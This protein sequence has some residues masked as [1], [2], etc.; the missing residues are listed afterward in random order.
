MNNVE[1]DFYRRH[2][3]ISFIVT[4]LSKLGRPITKF[5]FDIFQMIPIVFLLLAC[6]CNLNKG[7]E[8]PKKILISE[9]LTKDRS[10]VRESMFLELER[11]TSYIDIDLDG[12]SVVV[13]QTSISTNRASKKSLEVLLAIDLS[14]NRLLEGQKYMVIG[15]NPQEARNYDIVP[16]KP[17]SKFK[18]VNSQ[19]NSYNWLNVEDKRH[20]VIF[21]VYSSNKKIFED[22]S[23][24]PYS[25][26]P[27]NQKKMV[28]DLEHY[29]LSNLIDVVII[30]GIHA[31]DTCNA[32][33]TLLV[34]EHVDEIDSFFN[35]I[36]ASNTLS[37]SRCG[38]VFKKFAFAD[39]KASKPTPGKLNTS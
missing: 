30:N 26:G 5:N 9:I 31:A 19:L 4:F 23:V 8:N 37:I 10:S 13:A 11:Y 33:H 6:G 22:P 1:N 15:R 18:L 2:V 16:F 34:P 27:A 35:P 7:N 25:T 28:P 14:G 38:L 17:S 12:Y 36:S 21:L 29:I 39:Y 3:N 20:L 24:W 32:L